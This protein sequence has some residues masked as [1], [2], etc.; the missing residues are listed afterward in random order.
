MQLLLQKSAY[1]SRMLYET[2]G[3]IQLR[4]EEMKTRET[5]GLEGLKRNSKTEKVA[6]ARQE[7]SPENSENENLNTSRA[8]DE[9]AGVEVG[10]AFRVKIVQACKT[11][12]DEDI[13]M[14]IAAIKKPLMGGNKPFSA[15]VEQ[16]SAW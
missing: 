5:Q 16:T 6:L 3:Q 1:R 13:Q 14:L 12:G 2:R 11:I 8:T 4:W 7:E 10:N 9:K 15:T